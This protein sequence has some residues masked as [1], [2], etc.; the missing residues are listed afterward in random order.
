ME[1][2]KEK[3]LTRLTYRFDM[4]LTEL[5]LKALIFSYLE[6]SGKFDYFTPE[7]QK[8]IKH[9]IEFVRRKNEGIE[10]VITSTLE[11]E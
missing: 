11:H 4:T 9:N 10:A 5:D 3:K 1:A 2:K 6:T 7:A 8:R